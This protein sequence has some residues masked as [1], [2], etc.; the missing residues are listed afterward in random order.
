MSKIDREAQCFYGISEVVLM[1]NAG[2][3]VAELVLEDF[4]HKL[5][6]EKIAVLCGK[7]NNGGDGFVIARY[8]FNESPKAVV[9]YAPPATKIKK[10]P[11]LTNYMI[12]K[13]MGIAIKP[14]SLFLKDVR[15]DRFT[16]TVDALFGTGFKGVLEGVFSDLGEAVN[17]SKIK[18]RYAV[19]IPSGLDATTGKASRN[20]LAAAKTITFG[21]PKTGFYV[22]DGPFL[23][24]K[25]IV[26]NICF[27]RRLLAPYLREK[28]NRA[29]EQ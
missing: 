12:A 22:Q 18:K 16:I 2:K 28:G 27:P 19:D 17:S 26:K 1:E 10:G 23:S 7:G 21:L 29:V 11:A 3:A 8:L 24:G 20:S 4:A 13:K 14:L 15:K 25:V 9:I 5:K 6:N